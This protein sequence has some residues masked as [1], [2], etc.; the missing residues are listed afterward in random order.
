MIREYQ[1]SFEHNIKNFDWNISSKKAKNSVVCFDGCE[2]RLDVY[3]K[4]RIGVYLNCL[5]ST[6]TS[7][8]VPTSFKLTTLEEDRSEGMSHNFSVTFGI[9]PFGRGWGTSDWMDKDDFISRYVKDNSVTFKVEINMFSAK[10]GDPSLDESCF[11]LLKMDKDV[12]LV[13]GEQEIKAHRLI[14][15]QESTFFQSLLYPING[16]EVTLDDCDYKAT[17]TAVRFIYTKEC[18]VDPDNFRKVLEI[19]KK[20]GLMDLVLSCSELLTPDN[21]SL[22]CL[23]IDHMSFPSSI[24]NVFWS[25]AVN[26]ISEVWSSDT[27]WNLTDDEITNFIERLKINEKTDPV[28]LKA[29]TRAATFRKEKPVKDSL[30]CVVCQENKVDTLI[31]PCNHLSLCSKDA[32]KLGGA[33]SKKCPLCQGDISYFTKVYLP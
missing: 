26:N 13:I 30:L 29:I 24:E 25:Y 19:G 23:F 9:S 31:L 6:R 2:W 20:F 15:A 12:T 32:A 4:D 5:S 11:K 10:F 8:R 1:Y 16:N 18:I 17:L 22:Y 33:E 3:V 14:L 28:Q 21:F 27:F 7:K